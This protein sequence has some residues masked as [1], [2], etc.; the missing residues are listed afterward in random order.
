MGSEFETFQENLRMIKN[1]FQ[2]FINP[3]SMRKFFE[4]H[5]PDLPFSEREP[6]R[7]DVEATL[8][9]VQQHL[10][11]DQKSYQNTMVE[12]LKQIALN[13]NKMDVS[14]FISSIQR[15]VQYVLSFDKTLLPAS[16]QDIEEVMS[17]LG[18]HPYIGSFISLIIPVGFN[19]MSVNNFLHS[20]YQRKKWDRSIK[21]HDAYIAK[22]A[23]PSNALDFLTAD[24]NN[25]QI[26]NHEKNV[27]KTL[28]GIQDAM[29]ILPG[30]SQQFDKMTQEEKINISR[31]FLRILWGH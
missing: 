17:L 6:L 29:Q 21:E 4:D 7:R 16:N 30:F 27:T 9:E 18:S 24:W 8:K 23:L 11:S 15:N 28:V 19:A 10:I 3:D 25:Y 13:Q 31:H 5:Y 1:Q 12:I 26:S 22:I 20:Y 2:D 14:D